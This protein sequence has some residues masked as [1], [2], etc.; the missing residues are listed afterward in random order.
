M[1]KLLSVLLVVFFALTASVV[2]AQDGKA[3]FQSKGCTACHTIGGGKLVGP[4]L[5]GVTERREQDWLVKFIQS[6]QT[7]IKNGDEIAIK[8]FEENNKIPMPDNAVTDEEAGALIDYIKNYD[9]AKAKA[10]AAKTEEKPKVADPNFLENDF[11]KLVPDFSVWFVVFVLILLVSVVDLAFTKI[12]KVKFLH[13]VAILIS[14][15][16]IWEIGYA[17]ARNLGRTPGFEPDQPIAFSHKV[18]AG[19][20]NIDCKY[21][22]FGATESKHS[23]IPSVQLCLNCHNVIKEGTNTGKDEIAKIHA[24]NKEGKQIEWVKVHNL[25]DHV[26]FSHAQHVNAGKMD[27]A[28]CHGEVE[29]MGRLQQVNDLS[30]GWCIDCHRTKEVQFESNEYYKSFTKLHEKLK[31]GEIDKVTPDDIG[32]NDCQKCHY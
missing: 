27:C 10:E 17:E 14:A 15:Y 16:V 9:A 30:M 31:S 18:H 13:V 3:L 8:V 28:E 29:K 11:S 12:L 5:K 26:Y 6:S 25:P 4:D 20:N 23:G 2:S 22:H 21:C 1:R 32:A 24:A 7:M 19:E